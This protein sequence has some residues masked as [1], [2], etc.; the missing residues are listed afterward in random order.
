MPPVAAEDVV[1]V[2][3]TT[4]LGCGLGVTAVVVVEVVFWVVVSA[5]W[6]V[7]VCDALV[8]PHPASAT[9]TPMPMS[10]ARPMDPVR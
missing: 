10:S 4:F 9:A 2:G 1:V 7:V 8:P 5:A 3:W 6:V